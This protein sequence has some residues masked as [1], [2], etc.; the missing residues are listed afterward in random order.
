MAGAAAESSHLD[1]QA[2]GSKHTGIA[3]ILEADPEADPETHQPNKV[4][5]PNLSGGE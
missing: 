5:P 3:G 1:S 2:R 4:T